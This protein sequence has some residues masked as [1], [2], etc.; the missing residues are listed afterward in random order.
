MAL[1][2]GAQVIAQALQQLG[3][4]AVF[5]LVGVPVGVL[6]EEII[7]IGIRFIGFRNEQAASYAASIYGFLTGKP[8]VCLVV[9]G[10][11]VLH[12]MAGIGNSSANCFPMLLLAGSSESYL[13][14]KG[15]FQELDAVSLLTPHTKLALRPSRIDLLPE[16]IHTAYRTSLYGVPGPTVIDLP[17]DILEGRP[18]SSMDIIRPLRALPP[19]PR[20][21]A[22][23]SKVASVAALLKAS[24][25]PLVVIGKGAA[26]CRAEKSIRQF[27]DLTQLPFLP[28]PMGKG[29][30]PDSHPCNV[31]AARSA[32]L[33]HA[34]TVL[35]LGARLNWILHYGEDPKWNPSATIIQVDIKPEEI[36]RTGGNA[37]LGLVGDI[38]VVVDQL[39]VE[40]AKNLKRAYRLAQEPKMAMTYYRAFDIIRKT[41]ETLS[42][43]EN[44]EILWIAEGS[45][46][47]DISRSI[48]P[49]ESPR[50]RL[51]AGTYGTMGI[52]L[53]YAI[54]AHL[55]HNELQEEVGE[56]SMRKSKKK[57]VAI[58]GDSAFGFSAMEVETMARYGMDALIF[59]IN[60]NG[61]YHGDG[62]DAEEWARKKQRTLQG[63][64][65]G[66]RSTSLGWQ[67]G[68]EG[69][70]TS[71]GGV[72]F[73]ART[74]AEL[75]QATER[76][77]RATIPAVVNVIIEAGSP[78]EKMFSWQANRPRS[79]SS[80]L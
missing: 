78:P 68:Y 39:R 62:D 37:T 14:T 38:T 20:F 71:C 19:A 25:A 52:G 51:D 45:N 76:A 42:S 35:V 32:A 55:V 59:V 27:I 72:G 15:A 7:K 48:F 58:E 2:T 61:I 75:A 53:P 5:G 77:Y 40:M 8:G 57:I 43:S 80:K 67:V 73:R 74:P 3:V 50:S 29:V 63:Q 12:A 33:S 65:G 21:A 44:G 64:C 36:G 49:V 17:G 6:G 26:Y 70:A 18:D 23:P 31:S 22:D 54:A 9:G 24:K 56:T 41:L 28:T 16:L 79:T 30:V 10:P 47:M 11:G 1:P 46:T 13:T 4:T 60:N 66:L 34:D 69:I